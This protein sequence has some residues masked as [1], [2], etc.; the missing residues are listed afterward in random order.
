MKNKNELVLGV[1][2]C[3]I[4]T[5][6]IIF[7]CFAGVKVI[8]Y[9]WGIPAENFSNRDTFFGLGFLVG[10]GYGLFG[11]FLPLVTGLYEDTA[12]VYKKIK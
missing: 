7:W 1:V 10:W 12:K 2:C 11:I 3:V 6:I 4:W 5:S 8:N 9:F